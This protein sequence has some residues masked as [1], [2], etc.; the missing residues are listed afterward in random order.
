MP[1]DTLREEVQAARRTAAAYIASNRPDPQQTRHALANL[2][3]AHSRLNN[4]IN[5]RTTTYLNSLAAQEA[6]EIEVKR[7]EIYDSP[8]YERA[9]EE[10]KANRQEFES[11]RQ[12]NGGAYPKNISPV[13]YV[14]PLVMVGVAEWYVNFST[15]AAMF[16][17]VFAIAATVIVAAVFAWA[18]HMHGAFLKQIS[19]IFHPSVVYRNVLGRKL[20]MIIATV[21]LVAAFGVVVWLRYLVISDQL[22]GNTGLEGGTF[23]GG[24]GWMI[25]AKVGPTI[26]LN[27]LIWGLGTLYSWAMNEKVPGLRESYRKF[28]RASKK[29]ERRVR[30]FV[31]EEK[32]L[33][34]HFNRE[35]EKNS[36]AI[37]EYK[38]LLEEVKSEI[39]RLQGYEAA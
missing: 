32:R 7:R 23:G 36:V 28:L 4:D 31:A 6:N 5:E 22:G 10:Q 19:E 3:T 24:S 25:W 2:R 16:I 13:L 20:A 33:R 12:V 34:A 38:I 21:L 1:N 11:L 8:R 29:V 18:S 26:V 14:I 15:F 27:V 39:D 9:Y 30:P 37:S 17:P 35:R